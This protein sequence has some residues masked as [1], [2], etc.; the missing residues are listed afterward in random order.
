MSKLVNTN[1]TEIQPSL[2]ALQA[3]ATDVADRL[4][5]LSNASRLLVLCHLLEGEQSVGVLQSR[6]GI[7]QSALSQHLAWQGDARFTVCRDPQAVM[8]LAQLESGA[9]GLLIGWVEENSRTAWWR[10]VR[11]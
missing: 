9:V 11:D 5:L 3:R 7:S 1:I 10:M 4:A 8:Q 6:L 2:A